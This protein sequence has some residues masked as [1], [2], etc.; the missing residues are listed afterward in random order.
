[1]T[2]KA[3]PYD[4]GI[5]ID[6]ETHVARYR[7]RRFRFMFD[8]GSIFDVVAHRDDSDLR[9][10]VLAMCGGDRNIVGFANLGDHDDRSIPVARSPVY[11]SVDD[12]IADRST[13]PFTTDT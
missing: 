9:Q 2:R 7:M 6:P 8:D 4:P 5:T 13:L 3:K 12:A 1:M 10:A 11:A